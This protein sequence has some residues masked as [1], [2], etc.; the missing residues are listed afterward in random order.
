MP[1]LSATHFRIHKTVPRKILCGALFCLSGKLIIHVPAT[2]QP[3]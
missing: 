3:I 1:E 2:D